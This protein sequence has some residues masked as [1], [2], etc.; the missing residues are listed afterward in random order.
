MSDPLAELL[1]PRRLRARLADLGLR[2]SRRLGQHFLLDR[3]AFERIVDLAAPGPGD[4]VLEVGPGT[5]V[6]T[7][8][9][10]ERAGR[11]VAIEADRRFE[12]LLREVLADRPN[13][14]VVFGDALALDW[15]PLLA[16]WPGGRLFAANLPYGITSPVLLRLVDPALALRRA[17][18]MVQREVAER[19]VAA[20]GSKAYG[21]L[22]VAVRLRAQ[23]DL[24][25]RVGRERFWPRPEV[26]S[27]VVVIT[28]VDRSWPLPAD[29]IEPVVRAVFRARRKTL[30]N[31]LATGL[32]LPRPQAERA[33]AGAGIDGERRP[34]TL[35]PEEF[36]RLAAALLPA[37]DGAV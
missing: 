37:G 7:R 11:V 12:P 36:A 33:L 25:F 19:L 9:L 18:V 5:G 35:S 8:L 14:Q 15:Q 31:A 2:P 24:A 13:A 23:V 27:A 34:E 1:D 10:A 32:G 26:E 4:A 29:R 30:R 22:T 21:A 6:L 3:R 16:G 20:P 17:V 28:P